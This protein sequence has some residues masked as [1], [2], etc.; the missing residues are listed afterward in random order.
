V[1]FLLRDYFSGYWEQLQ[2]D[3]MDMMRAMVKDD[4]GEE[5]WDAAPDYGRRRRG[6]RGGGETIAI[7]TLSRA[8][9]GGGGDCDKEAEAEVE[10]EEGQ[11]E[12][13]PETFNVLVKDMYSGEKR[14]P[15]ECR[16]TA[17][18]R[19]WRSRST[20]R[21][22]GRCPRRGRCS[23]RQPGGGRQGAGGS[24]TAG[25]SRAG[26]VLLLLQ[27]RG[28]EG[29]EE[30]EKEEGEG[31]GAEEDDDD[32]GRSPEE[33]AIAMKLFVEVLRN[34][35]LDDTTKTELGIEMLAKLYGEEPA[36]QENVEA[37]DG[38]PSRTASSTATISTQGLGE[39]ERGMRGTERERDSRPA[40][41]LH[42]PQ[43]V[44]AGEAEGAAGQ[45]SQKQ[46]QSQE[47]KSTSV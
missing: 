19:S 24:R 38:R 37:V 27:G 25:A 31:G 20:W 17:S 47:A 43:E 11:E 42:G 39:W 12:E 5:E 21:T 36:L 45:C 13:L 15:A 35:D 29:E 16:S 3:H 22:T 2:G 6:G 44:G 10:K 14:G 34:K 18:A 33:Q 40:G 8:R 26:A 9:P 7:P 32:D 41:L 23:S 28:E 1:H 46:A 30:K 4:A